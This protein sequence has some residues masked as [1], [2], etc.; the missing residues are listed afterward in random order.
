MTLS[1]NNLRP[2]PGSTRGKIRLGRGIGSG[3]G[4]TC[5][6]GGKGQ[7]ARR[8]VSIN[9]FEGGQTPIHRRL[10]KR[11][12]N[13]HTRKDYD[14]V[15]VS[16]IQKAIEEKKI[17]ASAQINLEV[18]MAAGLVKGRQ[19]GVK[20]LGAGKISSK[21]EVAVEKVTPS[22]LKAVE[23]AGGKVVIV[24]PPMAIRAKGEKKAVSKAAPKTTGKGAKKT[25]A[26]KPAKA[27]AKK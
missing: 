1:L 10:P 18:L 6:R 2:N 12:F 22:A 3:K 27:K 23:A 9:G 8:G 16:D 4:K 5:G 20:L 14:V 26:K 13:N 25:A 21:V 17:S 19:D 7:T 15:N 24:N 11:G